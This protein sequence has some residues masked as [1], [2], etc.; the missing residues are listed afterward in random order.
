MYI[1]GLIITAIISSVLTLLL[2]CCLIIGKES[3]ERQV[4]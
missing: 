2:H 3:D 1:L 4:R